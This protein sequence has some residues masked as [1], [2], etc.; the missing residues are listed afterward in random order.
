[1]NGFGEIGEDVEEYLDEDRCRV[2][3]KLASKY[4]SLEPTS[5]GNARAGSAGSSATLSSSSV[6]L[7]RLTQTP[8]SARPGLPFPLSGFE[9]SEVPGGATVD[10][11]MSVRA[12]PLLRFVSWLGWNAA[13]YAGMEPD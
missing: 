5:T 11:D 10:I 12:L 1:M 3:C 8:E 9:S 2:S 7:G 13:R 6:F 4:K